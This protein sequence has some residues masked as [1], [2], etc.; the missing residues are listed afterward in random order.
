MSADGS[1]IV[2]GSGSYDTKARVYELENGNWILK[3]T[4]VDAGSVVMSVAM[5]ADGSRMVSG[6]LDHKARVYELENGNWYLKQTLSD[7][8]SV[9]ASVAISADGKRMVSGSGDKKVR[10]YE[11]T[12][13]MVQDES[14]A[15]N[16][17]TGDPV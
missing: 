3:Q 13:F 9:V 16:L 14:T 5:S 7:S 15:L 6:S 11:P 17:E 12:L 10:V 1:R 8:G 2:S 4:L